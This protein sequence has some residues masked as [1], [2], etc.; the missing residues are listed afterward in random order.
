M[1]CA[2]VLPSPPAPSL[3]TLPPAAVAARGALSLPWHLA[4]LDGPGA[5]LVV[6]LP[7]HGTV[8]RDEVLTDPY[9]SRLH[10]EVD[11]LDDVVRVRDPGSA[12][13]TWVRS[14]GLWLRMRRMREL[15]AGSRL[16][17]GS[18]VVELRRRPSCLAVPE[19]PSPAQGRRALVL[20][21]LMVVVICVL[22]AVTVLTRS[23]G[24]AGTLLIAPM[25]LMALSR[26]APALS[27][28]GRRRRRRCA[29]WVGWLRRSPD[30]ATMLM[31]VAVGADPAMSARRDEALRAWTGRRSRRRV[32]PLNAGDRVALTGPGAREALRW[33]TAQVIARGAARVTVSGAR[34]GLEWGDEAHGGRAE[35]IATPQGLAPARARTVMTAGPGAPRTSGRWWPALVACAGLTGPSGEGDPA[36]TGPPGR[37]VLEEVTGELDRD[38][39]RRRWRS[40]DSADGGDGGSRGLPAVL[41]VGTL[42]QC[43][44]DL[45]SDGPHAL[46]AGTTGSGKSELLT[47]WLIQLAASVPPW[48]LSLVLVDYKGGATF[49]PLADLPHTAGVLTDLDPAATHRALSS[50]TAETR[51]RE[52]LLAEHGAKDVGELP[53]HHAPARLVV[54]VDEFATLASEHPDVLDA[55]VRVAAQGR[56][57]GIHLVLAT[58]RP[59]GAVSPAIRANTTV[60][61]CLRVLDPADSRDVL[62]HDG[63]AHLDKAPG[64][65]LIEGAAHPGSGGALQAPWCGT[66]AQLEGIVSEITHAARGGRAP[67]RPWA[68]ELPSSATRSQARALVGTGPDR[69]ATGIVLALTDLP[70]HQRLGTWSWDP[71][72]PLLVLGA[73]ASGRTTTARSAALGALHSGTGVHLC[74]ARRPEGA[75]ASGARGVGTVVGPEDPRRLARLWSLAAS[76]ALAGSLVVVDDVEAMTAA[77]DEALGPGEGTALLDALTRTARSTGTG[78]LLTAPLAAASARW[79]APVRLRLVQGACQPAQASVAGLPRSV[80]TGRLPGRAVLLDGAQATGCQVLLPDP[81]ERGAPGP[82]PLRLEPLP[83]VVAPLPGVWAVGGDAA[84][85]LDP[86]AAPVLVVGPAGSGRTT[87]LRALRRVL[88]EAGADPLVVDDLDRAG[89]QEQARVEGELAQDRL[90]LAAATTDRVAG[91]FRGALAS[92]RERG[93]VLLL[94][95]GLGPAAQVAGFPV[96]AAVDPRAPTRPG[97]GV[98]IERG[99]TVVVQVAHDPACQEA[100]DATGDRP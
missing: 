30:P 4:I 64:R 31:A 86:P 82:S 70:E 52:R 41:G 44:V 49:G 65:V 79:S 50:L 84:L 18:T 34:T 85:P 96:R 57:L 47:S 45:V 100:Q 90:V 76:G 83:P 74:L 22:A 28:R 95:P 32:L 73:P 21:V 88:S 53:P 97:H 91:T 36:A 3:M 98:L 24:A 66:S 13:G 71:R 56:S 25:L 23:R 7:V 10:L 51:R 87:A 93:S 9:A 99:R 89:P 42:G 40:G 20:P 81:D 29:G 12:N 62:G 46:M 2:P 63:A 14:H 78:L 5:G 59:S 11:C 60:R 75:L 48:R 67:W 38:A 33:W 55:L 6:P 35:I 69:P 8:G 37:V 43:T 54:A 61:V 17:I 19:P 77:V 1:T 39:V 26:A 58:Q 72:E 92:M 68:P 94:W 80:V 27:G 16:R 15:P